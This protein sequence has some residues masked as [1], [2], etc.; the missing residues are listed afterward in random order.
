MEAELNDVELNE[1]EMEWVAVYQDGSTLFSENEDG[2]TSDYND[3]DRK[4]LTEF[5]LREKESGK[6]VIAI[7][8]DDPRQRLIYRR[9]VRR[10]SDGSNEWA[11]YLVGWQRTV[12]GE[13]IQSLN[14]VFPD[15][16]IINTGRFQEDH[17]IFYDV[18]YFETELDKETQIY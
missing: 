7:A 16:S 8:F 1:V 9:R 5:H 2:T 14:W 6:T 4:N 10:S 17:P 13:N 18:A 15:G 3:I 11:I 12:A